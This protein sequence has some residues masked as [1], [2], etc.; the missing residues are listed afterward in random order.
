MQT[1]DQAS[2]LLAHNNPGAALAVLEGILAK[3]PDDPV[4]QNEKGVALFR[5]GRHDE[6]IAWFETVVDRYP[7]YATAI[8]NYILLLLETGDLDRAHD[9]FRRLGPG[10]SPEQRQQIQRAIEAGAVPGLADWSKI[11]L[12]LRTIP[13]AT[14]PTEPPPRTTERQIFF[15]IGTPKSGTTWLQHLVN[16]HPAITCAGEGDFNLLATLLHNLAFQYDTHMLGVNA[17][18]GTDAYLRF[19]HA[20]ILTL[21]R[22]AI[23]LLFAHIDTGP[24]VRCIGSKNPILI[25]ALDAY[26][27][28]LPEAKFIHIIRDGRDAAVSAWFNNLRNTGGAF[29]A[30]FPNPSDF[31]ALFARSWARNVQTG[32]AFEARHPEVY[33][34][35]RYEDLHR[36]PKETLRGVLEFLGVD[37]DAV[38]LCLEAGDFRRLAGGRRRGEE[39]RASF[40]RKGVVGDWQNH[41]TPA[42]VRTFE[43]LAGAELQALGYC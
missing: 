2:A 15:I 30:Q 41:L 43:E 10:L 31:Y 12:P 36:S 11:P 34:E 29:Q 8:L 21:Y 33:H 19:S 16:G 5:L 24:E 25:H 40:Y 23:L 20:D 39:N 37:P 26:H 27:R 13:T 32:R 38:E 7:R 22:T 18:M 35:I 9:V 1:T 6:A 14:R 17:P 3:S 4:A 42:D 28:I